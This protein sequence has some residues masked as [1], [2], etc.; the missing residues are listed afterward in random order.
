MLLLI[1]KWLVFVKWYLPLV[2]ESH[3]A[4]LPNSNIAVEIAIDKHKHV[5]TFLES[6]FFLSEYWYLNTNI[7]FNFW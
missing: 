7:Q 2:L 1:V 4:T 5:Y 6:K 3:A